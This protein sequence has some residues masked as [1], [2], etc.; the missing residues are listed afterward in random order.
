MFVER[1]VH[2]LVQIATPLF[3]GLKFFWLFFYF[4]DV[5]DQFVF[6][7]FSVRIRALKQH[8]FILL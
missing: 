6:R 2:V 3:L 5:S 1:P 4:Y 7:E 8:N